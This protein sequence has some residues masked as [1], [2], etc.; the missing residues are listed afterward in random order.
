MLIIVCCFGSATQ[1]PNIALQLYDSVAVPTVGTASNAALAFL[2]AT[3]YYLSYQ[4]P[5]TAPG[6]VGAVSADFRICAYAAQPLSSFQ[7]QSVTVLL[8]E[9]AI[10]SYTLRASERWGSAPAVVTTTNPAPSTT[11][12]LQLYAKVASPSQQDLSTFLGALQTDTNPITPATVT[13]N[14][15]GVGAYQASASSPAPGNRVIFAVFADPSV[16]GA[17]A[18]CIVHPPS[19][20]SLVMRSHICSPPRMDVFSHMTVPSPL[21]RLCL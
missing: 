20:P 17:Q 18:V 14:D 1:L 16:P 13:P 3:T 19:L 2:S 5:A 8:N 7:T 4:I 21:C 15:A 10:Y 11:R 6:G 12:Y 9:W